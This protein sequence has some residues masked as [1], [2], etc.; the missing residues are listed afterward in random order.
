MSADTDRP[1][2]RGASYDLMVD[3]NR[4]LAREIP[5]LERTFTEAGNVHRVIDVGTGTGQHAIALARGGYDVVGVDPSA[6][7][8]EQARANADAA[9]SAAEFVEGGFG[10]LVALGLRDADALI[11]TGNALPHVAGL[12]ALDRALADFAAVLRPGGVLVLHL[13]NHVRLLESR[14][15]AMGPTVRDSEDVTVVFLRLFEYEPPET[16]ERIWI[17]FVTASKDLALAATG[18]PDLGWAATAHRSA[19]TAM[20]LP[21]LRDALHRSG[22][23]SIRAFGDH[24]GTRLEPSRHESVIV[25]A[26]RASD[27]VGV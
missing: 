4:R 21:V 12:A 1:S 8:L 23:G 25:T 14:V 10:G 3:W 11:S 9:G 13:L 22:F 18:D 27:A 16:P 26:R 17:E 5:F 19:H 15:R 20:P 24:E 7:M 2:S 6:E